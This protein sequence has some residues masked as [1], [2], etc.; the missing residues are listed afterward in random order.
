MLRIPFLKT[1]MAQLSSLAGAMGGSN[2]GGTSASAA[3]VSAGI[4]NNAGFNVTGSGKSSQSNDQTAPT[5]VGKVPSSADSS[6]TGGGGASPVVLY[7]AIGV[8]GLVAIA[9]VL[10]A[11]R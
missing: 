5:T 11:K 8:V 1:K 2:Y 7:V 4:T 3:D 9:A 6:A 10:S